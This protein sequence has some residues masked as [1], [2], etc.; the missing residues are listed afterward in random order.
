MHQEALA[1]PPAEALVARR[2]ICLP[3]QANP[4]A[5]HTVSPGNVR[6]QLNSALEELLRDESRVVLLGEDLHDPYGGAFKVTANLS[7]RFPGRVISTPI[8][9][10]AVAGTGIGLALE[11]YLPVIEV[12]FA[13]F[14]TL[15][16]D[17]IL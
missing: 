8:S 17:Q 11:G 6:V 10:A 3:A 5:E 16:M 9:E 14:V 4:A 1:S 2:T 13:D 12:M 7:T 15:S